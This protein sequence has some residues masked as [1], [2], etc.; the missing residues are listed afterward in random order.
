M[1]DSRDTNLTMEFD[2]SKIQIGGR[3]MSKDDGYDSR[4]DDDTQILQN[5]D[6]SIDIDDSYFQHSGGNK[7]LSMGTIGSLR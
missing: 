6:G 4:E 7:D 2:S 5:N 1:V 3:R